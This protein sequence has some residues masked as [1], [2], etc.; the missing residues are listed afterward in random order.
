[1]ATATVK[2][3]KVRAIKRGFHREMYDEGAV[4]EM[5]EHLVNGTPEVKKGGKVI[6]PAVKG[7]SWVVA[8][9]KTKQFDN[10]P[11]DEGSGDSENE[12]NENE[13]NENEGNENE[14]NEDDDLVLDDQ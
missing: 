2:T 11:E 9:N 8:V 13:G 6:K 7:A 3:I 10:N 1:M 5:E 4:F 12:G 14:G